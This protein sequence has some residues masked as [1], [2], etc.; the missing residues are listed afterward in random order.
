MHRSFVRAVSRILVVC[1]TAFSFQ[2]QAGLIGTAETVAGAQAARALLADQLARFG[3]AADA[4]RDRVAALSDAEAVQ[5]A[6]KVESAPAGADGIA[7]GMI[8]V[9]LFLFWRFVL[10]DQAKA[11]SAAKEKAPQPA[12]K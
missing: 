3:I 5:L 7:V 12:K 2:A 8:L 10:S 4:A 1:L 11:E 6:G 9:V